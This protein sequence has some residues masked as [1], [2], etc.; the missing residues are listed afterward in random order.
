[1]IE[2]LKDNQISI[3]LILRGI[4]VVTG[5]YVLIT[6]MLPWE[7]RRYLFFVEVC[8][9]FIL[10]SDTY[11]QL[12]DGDMSRLGWWMNRI[13][14]FVLYFMILA[15]LRGF[16][17]YLM[18]FA[19]DDGGLARIPAELIAAKWLLVAGEILLVISQFTGLYYTFDALNRYQRSPAFVIFYLF[20]LSAFALEFIAIL[21]MRTNLRRSRFTALILF[22][23]LPV[24]ASIIQIFAHGLS[25]ITISIVGVGLLLFIF[26]LADMNE[27]I[28]W[29][30]DLEIRMLKEQNSEMQQLFEE[31]AKALVNA[32][33]AKDKYT[34][35]HSARVAEYS[36]K[37]AE[38]AGKSREECRKIYYSALLHDVG[39]IGIPG[40]II[41]KRGALTEK[42]YETIKRHPT[43]G[44]RILSSITKYPFISTAARYHHE[45]YDGTG[46]PDGLARE[47]IPEI[48]RIVAVADAYDAMTSHRSYR[49]IMPQSKVRAELIK[50][51][52]TQF[53]P[54]FAEAM[55]ELIDRDK[56]YMMREM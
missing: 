18:G 28:E 17:A 7:R 25:L 39:K 33:D 5:I 41:N 51:S 31:T 36:M 45:R 56:T 52:G 47:D 29:S 3:L 38:A 24:A 30:R 53:D 15:F 35:G 44:G 42:E 1:M 10:M 20:P 46:Y 8:S 37:I 48:G 55:I 54:V 11:Y 26:E 40:M 6:K 50:G 9:V 23:V 13:S 2:I 32:I 43:I 16:N 34:Q 22:T 27:A 19:V 12:F 21:K 14:V 4:C 49:T